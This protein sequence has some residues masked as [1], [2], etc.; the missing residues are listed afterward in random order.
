MLPVALIA[1]TLVGLLTFWLHRRLVVAPRW[2]TRWR[3]AVSA[4]LVVLTGLAVLAQAGGLRWGSADD[5]RPVAFVALSWLVVA[6]YLV[7]GLAI[8]QLVALSLWAVLRGEHRRERRTVVLRR[9]NR[10]AAVGVTTAALGATAYG[11]AQARDPQVTAMTHDSPGLPAAFDGMRIA[12]VTDLH[13]GVVHGKDF[14]QQVVDRVNAARPDLV[15]LSGDVVDAPFQRHRTEVAP[16]AELDAPLGVFAVIGN[17]ELYTGTTR[18][19]LAEWERLGVTVLENESTTLARDGAT[20]R[21]AGVHDHDGTGQ[22]APDPDR[23]LA[24]TTDAFTLYAAHQPRMAL[25]SSG[26]GVDLQL[27]GH[28]HGGQVWPFDLLVPLQQPMLEGQAAIDGVPVITSRGAGTWGPP[29]RVGADPQIPV[30]TLRAA[31]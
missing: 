4:L 31:P 17:H 13:A 23:A 15:V 8:A 2:S 20:I 1:L 24:G 7:L 25:D 9:V 12:L 10:A 22:W 30:I 18:E 26:R 3:Y 19:W 29:V 11:I 14:T 27:S 21:L 6:L 16:L 5:T 28:T